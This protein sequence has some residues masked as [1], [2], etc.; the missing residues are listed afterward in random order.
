LRITPRNIV[1]HELI[2]LKV[3][4]LSHSDPTVVG[5]EGIVID[6]TRNTLVIRSRNG[7][8]RVFKHCGVF[9]FFLPNNVVV[10]VDGTLIVGRPED[11]LKRIKWYR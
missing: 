2:G 5:L 11:R 9:R 3:K 8:K 6:E 4:V 7:D 1:F 10:D